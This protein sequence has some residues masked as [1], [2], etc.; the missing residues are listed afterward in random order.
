M[1]YYEKKFTTHDRTKWAVSL[2]E[3]NSRY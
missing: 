1:D 2:D 3:H